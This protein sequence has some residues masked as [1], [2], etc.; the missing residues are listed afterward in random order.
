[1]MEKAKKALP[2][3]RKLASRKAAARALACDQSVETTS[4]RVFDE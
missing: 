2:L 1:M 4:L 3:A